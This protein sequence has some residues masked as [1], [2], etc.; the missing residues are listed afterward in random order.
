MS[1]IPQSKLHLQLTKMAFFF[2]TY[3]KVIIINRGAQRESGFPNEATFSG[4]MSPFCCKLPN[5]SYFLLTVCL[6][7][8]GEVLLLFACVLY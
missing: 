6:F 8:R 3:A 2:I 4:N 7:V 1:F 5:I